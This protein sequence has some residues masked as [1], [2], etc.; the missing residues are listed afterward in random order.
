MA[1]HFTPKSSKTVPTELSESELLYLAHETAVQQGF[2]IVELHRSGFTAVSQNGLLWWNHQLRVAVKAGAW[3]VESRSVGN[4]LI[5]WGKNR[6]KVATFLHG[7]ERVSRTFVP[8][9]DAD[10]VAA[11][12]AELPAVQPQMAE[13]VVKWSDLLVPHGGY[14]I[15]PILLYLNL[16]IYLVMVISGSHWLAPDVDSLLS[17]GANV[18]MLTADGDLWRLLSS[19]F[20]HI[21]L[22]HLLFNMYALWYIGLQLEPVLG[23][24]PFLAAYLLAGVVASTN[25]LWWHELT[26]SAGA[27]GAIFGMYGLFLALLTTNLF[28]KKVRQPLLASMA[29]FVGYN[30]LYG[31]QEGI[32]NAAHLGGLAGGLVLGFAYLPSLRDK[33]EPYLGM[34]TSGL[35]VLLVGVGV[36]FSLKY[37]PNDLATYQQKMEKFAAQEALALEVYNL[38]EGSSTESLLYG[39]QERGIYYWRENL[40]ILNTVDK[41]SLP[42]NLVER[43]RLLREYCQ[44]RIWHY[45]LLYKSIDEDSQ[46]YQQQIEYYDRQLGILLEKIKGE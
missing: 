43:N 3:E 36:F 20:V 11:W 16:A 28:H 13:T 2:A 33:A 24:W 7:F 22:V 31:T 39:L 38:P 34:A 4:E 15:T 44:T 46:A 35:M 25:S 45:R 29:V 26:V 42:A 27:S 32:D 30:L 41:L 9:T 6:R 37:L 1:I 18:R 19:C 17:W 8:E 12:Y 14:F 21:G 40:K 23:R 5:D 10:T